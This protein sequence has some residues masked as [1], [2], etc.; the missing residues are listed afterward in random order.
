M[1]L[2]AALAALGCVSP[3]APPPTPERPNILLIVADDLG[4]S[5]LGAYGS[6][7][8]TPHLD[9]LAASLPSDHLP[10]TTVW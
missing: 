8:P 4:Y 6:E 5:D 7:I 9:A 1:V 3:E 2:V 10:A